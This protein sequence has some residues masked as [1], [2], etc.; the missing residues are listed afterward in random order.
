MK[1]KRADVEG[2]KRTKGTAID[3]AAARIIKA[4]KAGFAEL[5]RHSGEALATVATALHANIL[6]GATAPRYEFQI[7]RDGDGFIERVD[8]IPHDDK[9]RPI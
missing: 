6:Q 7:K 4:V 5:E 9:E 8:A 3:K 2:A 1:M